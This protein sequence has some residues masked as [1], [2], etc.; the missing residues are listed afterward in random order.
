MKLHLVLLG[1]AAVASAAQPHRHGHQHFHKEKRAPVPEPVADYV[2]V[3]G[4]TEI[5]YVLNGEPISES[6]VQQGIKNGTLVFANNG[7]LSPASPK[8]YAPPT[9]APKPTS[10]SVYVPPTTKAAPPPPPPPPPKEKPSA[11]AP[12]TYGGDGSWGDGATGIDADFPDGELSC[13]EFPSKYGAVAVD[14]TGL[15]GWTGI[16]CPESSESG[17]YS[18]IRTVTSGGKCEEGSYCSYA[19][20]PGYQKAQWPTTQGST[21]QSVGGIQC[22]NGKLHLTNPD[23][24]RKLCMRGTDKVQVKVKN[25]LNK[26]VAVCRTDYP[27]TESETVPVDTQPGATSELT[28]P[29]ADNYYKWQGGSTSAQYYVNPAGVSVENACQWGSADNPWGNFAPMNLGVGYSNG[30]A[31]LSIF[32][33]APTTD[34]KLDFCVEIVGDGISG[35]CKYSNGQ[36]CGGAD[37]TS[38]SSTTG[39]T[40]SV[41]LMM[42]RTCLTFLAGLIELRYGNVRVLLDAT[43][44]T[45]AADNVARHA[46]R[47]K[48]AVGGGLET[49]APRSNDS[50][51]FLSTALPLL[52]TGNFFQDI[53][54]NSHFKHRAC[55]VRSCDQRTLFLFSSVV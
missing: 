32:Q 38:C 53:R 45:K 29:D 19:C 44:T 5:V 40:V 35:K 7:Q 21:G 13:D 10:T 51:R 27:G 3:P 14:W 48:A 1:A 22:K 20:P 28:C 6:E 36:Y 9:Y 41:K 15:G 43:S 16:Q 49:L 8:A 18:N 52:R 46:L 47:P 39:C 33:N 2:T 11:P 24:S 55:G 26:N 50:S 54:L 30:A 25:T 17:G 37:G 4:P 23:M 12:P 31:W 34:A 42:G